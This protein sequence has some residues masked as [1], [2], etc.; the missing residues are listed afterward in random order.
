MIAYPAID[1]L[2][3]R[4]VRL[5][6]GEFDTADVVANDIMKLIDDFSSAGI[7]HAHMVNLGGSVS[8][9]VQLENL[10]QFIDRSSI[11]WQ[12]GGGVRSASD[13]AHLYRLGIRRVIIGS[14]LIKN[15]AIV[16]EI[17]HQCPEMTPVAAL[18]VKEGIIQVK[19]WTQSTG[20]HYTDVLKKLLQKGVRDVLMTDIHRDGVLS[21]PALELYQSVLSAFPETRL[22]ASGGIRNQLD[23]QACAEIGCTGAVVGR[24]LYAGHL[25]LNEIAEYQD[26]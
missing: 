6:H 3:N 23:V 22:I 11:S 15:P 16:D 4:A 7:R 24:A 5:S 19:G 14:A 10:Q 2:E 25:S 17:R 12:F 8:G 1:I 21:G 18:D 9:S 13:A 20:I 26:V